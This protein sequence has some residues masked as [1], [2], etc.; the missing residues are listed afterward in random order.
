MA[1]GDG[2][3]NEA[4]L[5]YTNPFGEKNEAKLPPGYDPERQGS[6]G[7]AG[8]KMSR[9]A[10]PKRASIVGG[11]IS[12]A[13]SDLSVGAQIELEKENAI[14]YRTCSWRKVRLLLQSPAA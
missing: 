4:A 7:S 2:R 6:R 11:Q 13:E 12:D 14:K 8:R 3:P 5:E 9:I 1:L 10:P